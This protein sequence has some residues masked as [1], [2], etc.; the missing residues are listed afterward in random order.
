M[1]CLFAKFLQF[2]F[3][4]LRWSWSLQANS[5]SAAILAE[6]MIVLKKGVTKPRSW[7]IER[8]N[9]P[10]LSFSNNFIEQILLSVDV[11]RLFH[12]RAIP[13]LAPRLQPQLPPQVPQP[14]QASHQSQP[15]TQ[16]VNSN[17]GSHSIGLARWAYIPRLS[18][19]LG[20]C[21]KQKTELVS[22]RKASNRVVLT[23][24]NWILRRVRRWFS[25][26]C[27]AVKIPHQPRILFWIL[28]S[29]TGQ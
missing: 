15:Y 6:N 16:P 4:V 2:D 26:N 12:W 18:K 9:K 24:R 13:R 14:P 19:V 22:D 1:V 28:Q 27:L 8:K 25:S 23:A 17:L 11:F 3:P 21:T 10:K 5:S 20:N 7:S 29:S